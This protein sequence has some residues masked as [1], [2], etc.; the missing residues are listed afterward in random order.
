MRGPVQ[1]PLKPV[2]AFMLGLVN[3][4]SSVYV[5]IYVILGFKS[6]KAGSG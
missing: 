6:T 4:E 5:I 1:L 3:A 2:E